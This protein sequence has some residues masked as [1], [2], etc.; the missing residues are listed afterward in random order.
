MEFSFIRKQIPTYVVTIWDWK[1]QSAAWGEVIGLGTFGGA[2]VS[3]INIDRDIDRYFGGS[4][5]EVIYGTIKLHHLFSK[6]M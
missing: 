4:I 3:Q 6:M 2:L 5:D 1:N